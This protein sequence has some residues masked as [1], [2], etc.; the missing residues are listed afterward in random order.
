MH[1]ASGFNLMFCL[2]F[3]LIPFTTRDA[4]WTAAYAL[5]PMYTA[6]LDFVVEKEFVVRGQRSLT[7]FT[8]C[9]SG[10]KGAN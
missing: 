8:D 7:P 2:V 5:A 10:D 6:G 1:R 3:R 9:K 4:A